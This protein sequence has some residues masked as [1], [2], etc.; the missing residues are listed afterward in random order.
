ML[1]FTYNVTSISSFLGIFVFSFNSKIY[2]IYNF[3]HRKL[4]CSL[5]NWEKVLLK[6]SL[7][8]TTTLECAPLKTLHL[9]AHSHMFI[10]IRKW[11]AYIGQKWEINWYIMLPI[12]VLNIRKTAYIWGNTKALHYSHLYHVLFNHGI[13]WLL[14]SIPK[15]FTL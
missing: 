4:Y 7:F 10:W 8:Y 9:H 14:I 15:N 11:I 13:I 1:S 6:A 3:L 5:R 12:N 2:F